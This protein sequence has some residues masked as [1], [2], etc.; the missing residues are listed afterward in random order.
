VFEHVPWLAVGSLM[1]G[2]I[3]VGFIQFLWE[4][5]EKPGGRFFI[6]TI[7]CEALWSVAYGTALLVFDPGL[8]Q[9]FE[10]PIWI[11]IN[12]IGVFF[13][14]FAL[15]YTGRGSLLRSG[16]MAGV[17]G[18]QTLH[19]LVVAT[20]PLHH[21]AWSNYTIESVYGV[22]T[23]SYTHQPW[24]FIDVIGVIFLIGAASFLLVDTVISYGRLYR[25]QAAAI[26]ISPIF[27]GLPFLLWLIQVGGTPPLNFTPLLFPIHL[28]FDMYAFFRRDMFEMVPAARRVADRAA[29]ENLGSPVLIVDDE[30]TLIRLNPAAGDVLDVD[31]VAVLGDPLDR[32]LGDLDSEADDQTISLRTGGRLRQFAVSTSSL[33]DA[34]GA[35]VGTTMVLQDVTDERE[36]EQRLAVLNRVLRHNLRNDLNV[37]RGFI[38]MAR[39]RADDDEL[40]GYLQTAEENTN[41]VVELGEKARDIERIVG[42]ENR[43]PARLNLR[44]ELVVIRDGVLTDHPDAAI[45][46]EIP[47]S[48]ELRTDEQLL[49]RTFSNLL[50]NAVEH[51]GGAVVVR[52]RTESR[53][54]ATVVVATVADR[55]PG[56]PDH[57]LSVLRADAET[58]LEHG[59]GLGLWLV[60]WAVGALG[61]TIGF[62]TEDGT[63]ATLV[64]PAA[65]SQ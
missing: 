61:G 23:V 38:D 58:A 47:E 14:A 10:I 17:V 21:L 51:G 12:F 46:L 62:D 30:G 50:T 42:S 59:S 41:D 43:E 36:R 65:P 1:A 20:N 52:A 4:H 39:E 3:S 2:G 26:A 22:A 56:I 29:V 34:S 31:T 45:S 37:V 7:A 53:D 35:P 13:L 15:E 27:P 64:I 11:A 49:A 44:E 54:G 28:A 63:T 40:D 48:V 55:G 5:R 6:A 19:T 8:R 57:E 16:W 32:Y 33:C 60:K 24:L 25:F 18:I 9:L